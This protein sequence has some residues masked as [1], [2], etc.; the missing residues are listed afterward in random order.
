MSAEIE[1]QLQKIPVINKLVKWG[2]KVTFKKLEGLSLYDIMELYIIG[3]VEGAFTNRAAAIAFSFFMAIFPFLLF[4]LNLLPYM[5]LENFQEDFFELLSENV[6]PTTF[7]AIYGIIEDI[8]NNS[9]QGMLSSGVI[10]AV[11][12]MANGVNAMLSGFENSY[13]VTITRNFIK[14]YIVSFV[15]GIC[16]SVI[17]IVGVAIVIISEILLNAIDYWYVDKLVVVEVFRYVL[18]LLMIWFCVSLLF[19]F[20]SKQLQKT[21]LISIGSIITT[22]LIAL[23]S[24]G[25]GIYVL[26]FAKYNELYGS[27]GTLLVLMIYIWLNCMILLLGFELNA[28]INKLKS[29]KNTIFNPNLNLNDK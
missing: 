11:F 3:I 22:I 1:E 4:I 2:K 16:L 13:H 8:M 19:K 25:F 23:S 20:G 12:L 14:Q 27:I 15:L 17:L 5:P 21:A 29:E 7:D 9:N 10:L 28:A 6:P 24:Y 26:R 18:V